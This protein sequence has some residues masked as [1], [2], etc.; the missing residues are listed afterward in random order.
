M[1][2]LPCVPA[3]QCARRDA[4]GHSVRR[5]GGQSIG[6]LEGTL[7]TEQRG[8][9]VAVGRPGTGTHMPLVCGGQLACGFQVL[10]DQGGILVVLLDRGGDAPMQ[11][12]AIGFEL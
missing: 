12:R 6:D 3:N 9:D 4:H 11:L 10:G 8:D 1:E 2:P 5:V 7:P